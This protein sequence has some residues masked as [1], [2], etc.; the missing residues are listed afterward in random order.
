M[1][2]SRETESF[3]FL[4]D[5]IDDKKFDN[6]IVENILSDQ[7]FSI[8]LTKHINYALDNELSKAYSKI[9][10]YFLL[11]SY[12]YNLQN[13]LEKYVKLTKDYE[14]LKE[15]AVNIKSYKCWS[16]IKILT[17]Y[18]KEKEFCCNKALQYLS[19]ETQ[20]DNNFLSNSLDVLFEFNKE[21]AVLNFLS[22][23][24]RDLLVS[25]L[26]VSFSNYNAISNFNIIKELFGE[27]YLKKDGRHRFSNSTNF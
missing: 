3:K 6:R 26:D 14:V 17:A 24:K 9:R 18:K 1:E 20:T 15:C 8:V 19:L 10:E 21:E 12:E 2:S 25:V 27:I 23:L 5:K 22:L 16:A 4:F 7:L 13:Q 11:D